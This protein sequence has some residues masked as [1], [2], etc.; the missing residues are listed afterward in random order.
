[1]DPALS[2]LVSRAVKPTGRLKAHRQGAPIDRE[3]RNI[4]ILQR[5]MPEKHWVEE[6]MSTLL[7]DLV[8][9]NCAVPASL[10]AVAAQGFLLCR[11]LASILTQVLC[12]YPLMFSDRCHRMLLL[13]DTDITVATEGIYGTKLLLVTQSLR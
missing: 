11:R 8:I 2:L 13:G 9:I 3:R 4:M 5:A 7:V 6:Q 10:N 1:V 12:V